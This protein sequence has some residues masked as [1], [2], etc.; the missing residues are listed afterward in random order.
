MEAMLVQ[1]GMSAATAATVATTVQ[2]AST[3]FSVLGAISQ[4]NTNAD[5][6]ESQAGINEYNAAVSRNQSAAALSESAAAQAAQRRRARELLGEQRAGVAQ[7]GTG[8]GGT[9]ADLLE[10]SQ[11]LAELDALN[12]AYEGDMKSKGYL[13][14]AEIETMN[15][16][17]NRRN[18]GT[19]RTAGYLGAGRA[20][21]SGMGSYGRGVTQ[22]PAPVAN[23]NT[24]FVG[25]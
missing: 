21:L 22:A 14:Q 25:G 24:R 16:A 13:Q 15:A 20:L 2:I 8:F 12:L 19:A 4:A 6:Y 9:N 3:A 10:R 11:T 23:G 7:S 17:T 1:A 18:A 5:N